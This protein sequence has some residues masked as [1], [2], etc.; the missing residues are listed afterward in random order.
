MRKGQPPGVQEQAPYPLLRQIP[1]EREITIFVV[2]EHRMPSMREVDADLVGPAG[3]EMY[4]EQAEVA[5]L[6]HHLHSSQ[7]AHSAVV[8]ADAPLAGVHYIF[9]QGLAELEGVLGTDAF[10]D[11]GVDLLD[12]ALAQLPMHLDQRAALLAHDQQA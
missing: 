5:P 6:L 11:G 8:H 10:H 12:L 1:V 4:F 9:V 2:P 3:E 7:G